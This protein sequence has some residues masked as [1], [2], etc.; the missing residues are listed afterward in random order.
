M[1][2]SPNSIIIKYA[3][4]ILVAIPV[5]QLTEVSK[6]IFEEVRHISNWCS[7]NGLQLNP[8]KTKSLLISKRIKVSLPESFPSGIFNDMKILGL[9]YNSDCNWSSHI[10]YVSKKA[11][12]MFFV[13][14]H[15]KNLLPKEL[16]LRI[17]YG[18]IRS[19]VEYCSEV[20]VGLSTS[21]SRQL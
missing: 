2:L 1:P 13:L 18:L 15:L 21:E 4:D 9:I 8:E 6:I 3:D 16:L 20:F 5:P 19:Q 11:S 14:R 10:T 7:E 12:R 17:Y